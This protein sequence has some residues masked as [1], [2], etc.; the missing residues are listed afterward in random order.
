L[1][2]RA[3]RARQISDSLLD[4]D[5]DGF[6]RK[7]PSFSK[8]VAM[9]QYSDS[10]AKC[11]EVLFPPEKI[12]NSLPEVLSQNNLTQLR[13]AE[14]EKFA[15][16]TFFFSCGKEEEFEG[17]KRVLVPSPDVATYD[18]Q[19]EMSANKVTEELVAAIKS[20][21]YDFIVVN[22][23]NPDMVGHSGNL[24]AAIKAVEVIDKQLEILKNAILTAGGVMLVTADHGNIE[25]M[26]DGMG[27]PHTAHTTNLVPLIM[28]SDD[29][30]E[31]FALSNGTLADI[32]PTVIDILKLDIPDDMAGQSLIPFL[33]K[34]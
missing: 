2:F 15:H 29:I 10:L 25:S 8:S 23:A 20:D 19:P 14:T 32:A 24:Q 4:D 28:I 16:V 17:E 22:F 6:E 3:D 5:F 26:V 18:L 34:C 30:A 7:K 21:E 33:K 11:Y 31:G 27:K 9:T 1:Y 12:E 13:C